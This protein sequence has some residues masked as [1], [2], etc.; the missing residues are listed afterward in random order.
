MAIGWALALILGAGVA[1]SKRIPN[2]NHELRPYDPNP[3]PASVV[4]SSD[5]KMRF[6][7]LT[8]ML[9]RVEEGPDFDN[10]A[11][12][13]VVHRNLEKPPFEVFR[14]PDGLRIVT[15][16]I[17][18]YYR[19]NSG[20]LSRSSLQAVNK[21]SHQ[22]WKFGDYPS[23][24]LLGT[25]RTLDTLGPT[26]LNCSTFLDE[27]AHC[28]F[29]LISTDGWAILDDSKSPRIAGKNDWW[30]SHAVSE[31]D[32][33]LFMHGRNFKQAIADYSK[34]GGSVPLPPRHMLGILW[35]RWFDYDSNDLKDLVSGF[36][37]RGLPLDTL[38]IDMNWHIKPWWGS[39]SFDTRII[40]DPQALVQW[41]KN[42]GVAVA[43]NVHDCLLAEP[44]C[45]AGTLTSDDGQIFKS[46]IA[47]TGM[48]ITE[49]N[50][51]IPLDL[52]NETIALAK[53]DIV[54]KP[55]EQEIGIDMWWVDWQQGDERG[56]GGLAGN[57]ENPTIWFNKMRYTNRA[58][59]N[60]S[61]RASVLSRFGGMG[62]HRYGQGFSGDV[63]MLDW[64][65]L[66]YQPFF[67]ATAANVLFPLW[68]H[69]VTGPNRDPELLVRWTQWAAFSPMLRFHERGMSSGPC[70]YGSFPLPADEC[71]NVDLWA[72]LAGRFAEAARSATL[73][74][75]QLLPYIYTEV[76]KTYK[77]GIPWFRGLYYDFPEESMAYSQ[78][79]QYMFGD[80]IT[81]APVVA[82]SGITTP[83][84]TEWSIWAPPGLWYSPPDGA[85]IEGNT[86]YTRMWDLSEIPHLVR[87]GTLLVQRFIDPTR[88]AQ[89]LVGLAMSNYTD[90]VFE[91]IPGGK[92][93]STK[94]YEDDAS[95]VAYLHNQDIGFVH[96]QY[97]KHANGTIVLNVELEGMFSE[98][99]RYRRIH[100]TVPSS[101]PFKFASSSAKSKPRIHYDGSTLVADIAVDWDVD[102]DGTS[103]S[104]RGDMLIPDTDLS[105][106]KGAIMH[107][108]LS[109][110]ALD[111]AVLTPGTHPCWHGAPCG[112]RPEDS[113]LIQAAVVGERLNAA[114]RKKSESEFLQ[115]I[116]Q[117]L[118]QYQECL[119]REI[120]VDNV[121]R[122]D[123]I[124]A[125]TQ[126]GW[127]GAV[128][129]RVNYAVETINSAFGG[130]CQKNPEILMPLVCKLEEE[131]RVKKPEAKPP[132]EFRKRLRRIA[133]D[134]IVVLTHI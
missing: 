13:S 79:S 123:N 110:A 66:A 52:V 107:A 70:A 101:G 43:L 121:L 30:D 41:V 56:I 39:Y 34:I 65:N 44:G 45:P 9:V 81:V 103:I 51:T 38:I 120:T 112:Y 85:L 3:N 102:V 100:L 4:R 49:E 61:Q 129:L 128:R 20:H 95:T 74:R 53:E 111:E 91:I 16:D 55:L 130:I 125:P 109:K 40:P 118:D 57:R 15:P 133:D 54:F 94:I 93:G 64:D 122:V 78:E 96:A 47:K 27:N 113:N 63:Q 88:G 117:F 50:A 6:T 33:Y 97:E 58:R 5:G 24:N 37:V 80:D 68:S 7:I 124:W 22:H 23:G 119:D 26:N 98:S 32:F 11:S 127:P 17:E 82:K 28:E 69:D 126:G 1:S 59:W 134:D 115:I 8:S 71:A 35:T 131:Q 84:V 29:G 10:R 72:N 60:D 90:L 19:E 92:S 48:N 14:L 62:S 25:I 89:K 42:R 36:S 106:V 21:N 75:A 2:L 12:L 77:T 87:A 116:K 104:I 67:T 108:R 114:A 132:T 99:I 46:F 18:V 31:M 83:T 86:T 105:G 73:I 76:W